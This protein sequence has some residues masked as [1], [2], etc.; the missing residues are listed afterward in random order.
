MKLLL[1]VVLDAVRAVLVAVLVMMAVLVLVL[2]LHVVGGQDV[3]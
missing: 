1:T 3:D 2:K